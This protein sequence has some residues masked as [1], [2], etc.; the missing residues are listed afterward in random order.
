[1]QGGVGAFSRELAS[2][3]AQQGHELHILTDRRVGAAS[4]PYISVDSLVNGWSRAAVATARQWAHLYELD[5]VNIQYEAA[6][7]QMSALIHFLPTLIGNIPTVTTFHDLLVPYLFPKAGS[8]RNKALITLAERSAGVIVTN[9][10]DERQLAADAKIAHLSQIPIGSNVRAVLPPNY[11]RAVWRKRLNIP[12]KASLIGYFGFLNATK[13]VDT[14]LQALKSLRDTDAHLLI[15][16]GR[17]GASDPAN[18]AYAEQIDRLVERLALVTRVHATG[19]VD[20]STVSEFLS[21]CDVI[22]L[23]FKD[24]VS[25]RRGSFM[26]AITHGC[27]VVTTTPAVPLPEL[28]DGTNV[29]L[30]APD[31]P[32]ELADAIRA[33]I[34]DPALRTRLQT[35]ARNLSMLFTWDR[36]AVRTAEFYQEVIGTSPH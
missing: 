32:D 5:I 1:M 15:I 24:G 11:D 2:A 4:E 25:F 16:G 28:Q 30:V 10:Q 18:E 34:K 14:L 21:A 22:A 36:I 19:F 12:E 3:L 29:R 13:G 33:L 17:T 35:N 20:D 6:A 27:A 7:F 31:S 23:P 9:P 8:L 26:A